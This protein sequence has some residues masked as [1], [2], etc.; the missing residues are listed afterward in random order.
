MLYYYHYNIFSI[1]FVSSITKYVHSNNIW[2][3][4]ALNGFFEDDG[5][6]LQYNLL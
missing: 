1:R 6:I 5:E 4:R 3:V 2:L